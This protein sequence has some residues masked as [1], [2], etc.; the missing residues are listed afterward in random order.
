MVQIIQGKDVSLNQLIEEFDLQ[1]NDDENFFREWQENLPEL[2]D[3]ERQNIAE[4]KTEYQH[5]SRYP[6]LEPVV[7]MVVLS[8]L[9]RLAGFY[10]PPFYIASE[11]EVEISSEDEGTIIR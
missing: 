2:N 5:L 10:Q 7:K 9:L 6:I 1:R 3:L 11:E 4:I 8:P